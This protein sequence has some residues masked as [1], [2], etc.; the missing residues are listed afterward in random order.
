MSALT[1]NMDRL[2]GTPWSEAGFAHSSPN[3]T[4]MRFAAEE[5]ARGRRRVLDIGCGAG[6]NA[7][8]LARSG[9]IV[10]GID[11]SWPMLEAAAERARADSLGHR[12]HVV[13]SPMERLA[14][15]SA[16]I[17]LIV[18]HGIWNLAQSTAQFRAAVRE[19]ARVAKPGAA[20]FV[21]TFSRTTVLP[22]ARPVD[23]EEFVFT[24]FAGTPQCFVT[25]DQLIA[26]MADA[27]FVPDPSV[28]V[29][30]HNR[31]P[32]G[33]FRLGGPPVIHEATFRY[34]R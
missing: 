23:G 6:R 4:L 31:P 16:S 14:I 25:A 10:V 34:G 3:H 1:Q 21:F 24:E 26:E 12:M 32:A 18:A 11:L 5:H 2:R 7:V 29:T 9:W 27:G 33:G 8:P 19:A 15:A 13:V 22:D 28:P 20:L 17:D 30:E